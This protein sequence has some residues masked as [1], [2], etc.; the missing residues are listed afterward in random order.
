MR[1]SNFGRLALCPGSLKFEALVKPRPS[2]AAAEEGIDLHKK[3]YEFAQGGFDPA[4]LEDL[5]GE[6]AI[7]LREA[8]EF[9]KIYTKGAINI[10]FER[11]VLI[12]LGD[13]PMPGHID[14]TAVYPE[15]RYKIIDFK[16]GRKAIPHIF[17]TFQNSSY[18]LG[19]LQEGAKLV[20]SLT[21]NPRLGQLL[22]YQFS[23]AAAI[24][25]DL[26]RLLNQ[27]K[28]DQLLL[29]AGDEQCA[30]CAAAGACPAF[31][32]WIEK[33]KGNALAIEPVPALNLIAPEALARLIDFAYVIEPWAKDLKSEAKTLSAQVLF[34]AGYRCEE[35]KGPRFI[36]DAAKAWSLQGGFLS[37]EELLG[38][39][40]LKLTEF[41][42]QWV[43]RYVAKNPDFTKK[44]AR[45]EFGLRM[46]EV[47]NREPPR[48]KLEK[49]QP[50][51]KEK[52]D[53]IKTTKRG[54]GAV[55]YEDTLG[56]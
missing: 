1:P 8:M 2:S 43:E 48:F 25:R 56:G 13:E 9:F 12:L 14:I 18:A 40:K 45:I 54:A 53:A 35:S 3:F 20:D 33:E 15:G 36:E 19:L 49:I 30:F 28:S 42:K 47:I 4:Y 10:V 22:V 51:P 46:A 50:I 32:A 23:D 52:S 44:D 31:H 17:A 39:V 34:D 21:Y 41:E 7:P 16:F 29:R 55:S 6:Q 26:L 38:L 27:A 37:T 5:A 24:E 11:E